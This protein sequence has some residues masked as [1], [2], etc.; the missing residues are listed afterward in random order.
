MNKILLEK[1][2]ADIFRQYKWY[3]YVNKEK[4][5]ASERAKLVN[6]IT[7]FYGENV[8]IIYGDWSKEKQMKGVISVPGIGLKRRFKVYNCE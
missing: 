2:K 7:D 1:Y 5:H 8:I 4:A 6:E 3:G